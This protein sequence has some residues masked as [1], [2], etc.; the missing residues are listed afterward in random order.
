[1]R[2]AIARMMPGPIRNAFLPQVLTSAIAPAI[3]LSRGRRGEHVDDGA[4]EHAIAIFTYL[5]EIVRL[6]HA[7]MLP[8]P[9]RR[10]T[11]H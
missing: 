8:V 10:M 2:W 9:T 5:L 6:R 4:R 3:L 1:M 7:R 11:L